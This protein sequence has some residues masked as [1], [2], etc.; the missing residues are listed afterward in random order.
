MS[1]KKITIE[2]QL[3]TVVSPLLAY[4]GDRLMIMGDV[5]IGVDT[6]RE[7]PPLKDWTVPLPALPAPAAKPA[8]HKVKKSTRTTGAS[9]QVRKI[10]RD[11]MADGGEWT[12]GDIKL[13]LRTNGQRRVMYYVLDQM[14]RFGRASRRVD[15]VGTT[16]YQLTSARNAK[17]D[18]A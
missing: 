6:S 12:S 10:I 17:A 15:D 18:V 9:D 7:A 11:T 5:C 14:V 13:R 4:P 3:V 8:R 1:T 2:V 16:Y